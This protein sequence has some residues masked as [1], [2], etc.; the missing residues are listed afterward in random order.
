MYFKRE[1][2]LY[3]LSL[4]QYWNNKLIS[5]TLDSSMNMRDFFDDPKKFNGQL[6][7]IIKNN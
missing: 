5:Y 3:I 7:D 6:L 1:E 2:R 4:I